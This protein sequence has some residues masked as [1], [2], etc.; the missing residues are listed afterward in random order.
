MYQISTDDNQGYKTQ[1]SNKIN[2]F[3]VVPPPTGR[4]SD[5]TDDNRIR[6]SA[7]MLS[8]AYSSI[9]LGPNEAWRRHCEVSGIAPASLSDGQLARHVQR[10]E[11]MGYR[12]VRV[13]I[14]LIDEDDGATTT[15]S[16]GTAE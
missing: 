16:V 12:L 4:P 2:G 7:E 6:T 15:R 13:L 11:A 1:M 8:H 10:R 5:D 3:A 14:E 9:G